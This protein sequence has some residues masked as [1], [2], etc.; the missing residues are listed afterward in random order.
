M[1]P[2]RVDPDQAPQA[3][4]VGIDPENVLNPTA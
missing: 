4:L 2:G 1:K 3:N